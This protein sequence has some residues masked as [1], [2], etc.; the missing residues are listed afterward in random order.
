VVEVELIGSLLFNLNIFSMKSL[1]VVVFFVTFLVS[2]L[3]SQVTIYSRYGHK[4]EKI[5]PCV[6]VFGVKK[7]TEKMGFTYFALVNNTWAEAQIGLTYSPAKWISVGLSG[8]FEQN[9]ELYRF[10]GSIWMGK[11]KASIIVL[12]E[13]GD[14][15]DNYWY[16][17]VAAYKLTDN[18][19]LGA[20]A[21]R[22]HGIGPIVK[23]GIKKLDANL[24]LVPAAYDFEFKNWNSMLGI[25]IKI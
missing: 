10:G 25:D 12:A 22:F 17:S 4:S 2:N 14:G 16:K 5:T 7:I 8:G 1:V 20:V 19:S 24:W 18:F 6:T 3:F 21:W 13:H 11:G 9:P 15:V 23:L